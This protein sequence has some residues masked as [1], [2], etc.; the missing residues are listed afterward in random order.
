MGMHLF[1]S[2]EDMNE[3]LTAVLPE[4]QEYE[5]MAYGSV[6][7]LL[8]SHNEYCYMGLTQDFFVVVKTGGMNNKIKERYVFPLN[9]LTKIK[10]SKGLAMH[11]IKID[12]GDEKMTIYLNKKDG[13]QKT[14]HQKEN[15]QIIADRLDA[16]SR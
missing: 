9:E 16:L 3:F 14:K 8:N 13:V 2:D 15:A 4:G 5:A 1:M 6:K 7:S 11:T 10:V 12:D